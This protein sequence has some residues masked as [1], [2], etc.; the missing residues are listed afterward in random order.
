M[1]AI[2]YYRVCARVGYVSLSLMPSQKLVFQRSIKNSQLLQYSHIYQLSVRANIKMM[3]AR[4]Y[5]QWNGV[6]TET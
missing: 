1:S 4:T 6:K 3:D 2:N 5:I